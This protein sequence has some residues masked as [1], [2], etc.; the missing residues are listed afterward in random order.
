MSEKRGLCSSFEDVRPRS[1]LRYLHNSADIDNKVVLLC[2]Q[3]S[4]LPEDLGTSQVSYACGVETQE[5][6][7]LSMT[8]TW[9]LSPF[10]LHV[11]VFI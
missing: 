10:S 1:E 7:Q 11:S 9:D 6:L 3:T 2:I 5:C 8:Q 4:D